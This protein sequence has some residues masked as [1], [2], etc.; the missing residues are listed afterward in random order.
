[1]S[2]QIA[3]GLMILSICATGKCNTVGTLDIISKDGKMIYLGYP[4][5]HT[6]NPADGGILD[7]DT[8]SKQPQKKRH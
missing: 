5:G 8:K 6:S 3:I 4:G 2:L 1:V 7:S